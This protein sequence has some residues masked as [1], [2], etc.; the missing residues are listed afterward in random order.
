MKRCFISV[1][2]DEEIKKKIMEIQEKLPEFKG[3]KTEKENLHLTLKFL[4]EI[5][6]KEI[7]MSKEALKNLDFK[8]FRIKINKIGVFSSKFIRIIWLSAQDLGESRMLW[9]L[10]EKIDRDLKDLF[11]KEARF[12][13]HIT[14]GRVKDIKDKKKFLNG[15]ERINVNVE[16]EI[17]EFK[18]RKSTL[19][20]KGPIYEDIEVY[21]LN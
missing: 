5:T 16:S 13:G 10:Q 7:E 17:H 3:K 2:F 12:M 21:E 6:D 15:L 1:D 14:I 20:E 9:K 8:K 11:E 19:T 4:G 18:L